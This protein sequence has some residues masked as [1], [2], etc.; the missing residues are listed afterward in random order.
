MGGKLR[1]TEKHENIVQEFTVPFP[2]D[3]LIPEPRVVPPLVIF[4]S[5]DRR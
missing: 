2:W 3:R 4:P 1:N 5:S